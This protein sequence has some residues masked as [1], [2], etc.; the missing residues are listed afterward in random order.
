MSAAAGN[1][2]RRAMKGIIVLACMLPLFV[3]PAGAR[4][5]EDILFGIYTG[6]AVGFKP[7]FAWHTASVR[8]DYNLNFHVGAY[9]QFERP[10]RFGVQLNLNY[11]NGSNPWTY[12][13][14]YE[15]SWTSGT[16]TF[17]FSSANL[18]FVLQYARSGN[19][20]FYLLAGAGISTPSNMY[21]FE[22]AFINIVGG[23]GV[24]INLQQGLRSAVNLGLTFHHL[25][26]PRKYLDAHANLVRFNI[27][28]ET[29][30]NKKKN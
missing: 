3:L 18:N 8:N 6:W 1:E 9:V 19:S 28:L 15:G 14:H 26:D 17:S 30:L 11:Q 2:R 13:S 29:I 5:K 23:T 21:H 22:D 25:W 10:G 20:R 24:K 7:E 4:Q 27:G 16:N 12:Y